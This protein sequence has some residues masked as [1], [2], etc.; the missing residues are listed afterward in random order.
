MAVETNQKGWDV[1]SGLGEKVAVKTTAVT[2]G[3]GI[4]SFNPNTFDLG[5]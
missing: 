4:T 5:S 1:V 2:D 3:G